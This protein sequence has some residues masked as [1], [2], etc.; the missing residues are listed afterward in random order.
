M[1][2]FYFITHTTNIKLLIYI[3]LKLKLKYALRR[4]TNDKFNE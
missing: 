4:D 2:I 3:E 1:H